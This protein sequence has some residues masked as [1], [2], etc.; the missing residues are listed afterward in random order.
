MEKIFR[1]GDLKDEEEPNTPRVWAEYVRK[2]EEQARSLV[3]GEAGSLL[4]TERKLRF[5]EHCE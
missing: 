2:R 1:E 3:V 5:L 4:G